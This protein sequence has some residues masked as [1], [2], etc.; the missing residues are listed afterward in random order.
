MKPRCAQGPFPTSDTEPVTVGEVTGQLVDEQGDPAPSAHVQV[1][2]KNVCYDAT[3]NANGQFGHDY[4]E[5]MNAP[6]C[7]YGDGKAWGKLA[8]PLGAGD[9]DVGT[10]TVVA[11]PDFADGAPLVPGEAASSGGVTLSLADDAIVEIDDLTYEDQSEW[12]FRAA[13]LSET[14]LAQLGQDFVMGFA[15]APL[16]TVICP[17]P[18]LSLENS[19]GLAAGTELELFMQGHDVSEEWAAYAGWEKVG[20]G[21]VTEDGSALEFPDGLPALTSIGIRE[22]N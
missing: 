17:S 16:E 12:G 5:E 2:A 1:C 15:L 6:A 19:A 14:V 20:E 21:Q 8:L 9:S 7:K 3:L 4:G 13:P 18:V 11:L 22:K 10:L